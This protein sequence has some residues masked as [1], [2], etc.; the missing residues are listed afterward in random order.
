MMAK[1]VIIAHVDHG[2]SSLA[3]ALAC[4]MSARADLPKT[5]AETFPPGELIREEMEARG[6]TD[7]DLHAR[8]GPDPVDH[9]AVD[10]I[11]AVADKNL[12]LDA[13]TADALGRAFDVGPD[14]FLNLDRAWR[15]IP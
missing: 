11:L 13:S 9:C 14:F 2:K 15:G 4:A 6:W 1:R 10:L 3:A 5:P 7:D 8:L 12:I